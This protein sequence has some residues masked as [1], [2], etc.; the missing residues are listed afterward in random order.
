MYQP[1]ISVVIPVY[2]EEEVLEILYKRLF[3]A[4]DKLNRTYEVIFINDGSRDKSIELLESFY[5]RRP[6]QVRVI[7]F[8]G[9]WNRNAC[10]QE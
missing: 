1:F 8:N 6:D 9:N 5:Q 3:D 10:S 7:D 2:N 4:L